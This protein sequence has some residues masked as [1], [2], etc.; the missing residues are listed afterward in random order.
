MHNTRH[1]T[2][3]N[4]GTEEIA[5]LSNRRKRICCRFNVRRI[6]YQGIFIYRYFSLTA[7]S[8]FGVANRE[9]MSLLLSS[10]MSLRLAK[11]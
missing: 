9:A 5:T 10:E 11:A 3:V 8:T 1:D 7:E 6:S 4:K 2:R